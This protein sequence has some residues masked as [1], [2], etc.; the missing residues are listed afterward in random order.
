VQIF[1]TKAHR[2]TCKSFV[3]ALKEH[4]ACLQPAVDCQRLRCSEEARYTVV[5][6]AVLLE[7]PKTGS[8][9]IHSDAAACLASSS[10]ISLPLTLLCPGTQSKRT[11]T[12]LKVDSLPSADV[13]SATRLDLVLADC[14]SF[15]AA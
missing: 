7:I 9:H 6:W 11:G 5:F 13:V 15:S 14:K 10:A 12:L 8:G 2:K 4:F 1:P 3:R